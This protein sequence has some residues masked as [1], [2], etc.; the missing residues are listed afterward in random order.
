MKTEQEIIDAHWFRENRNEYCHQ[1]T[2]R[3][4]T[5]GP[6][7]RLA[8][9]VGYPSLTSVL[10]DWNGWGMTVGEVELMLA[11]NFSPVEDGK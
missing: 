9:R 6:L 2:N 3:A 7:A 1:L 11:H 4:L 5:D 8:V 10:N